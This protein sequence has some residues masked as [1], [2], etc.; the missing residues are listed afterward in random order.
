MFLVSSLR[1]GA[2]REEEEE[3]EEEEEEEEGKE[4][5]EEEEG[6]SRGVKVP[7]CCRLSF[8]S[9]STRSVVSGLARQTPGLIIGPIQLALVLEVLP[10][11]PPTRFS[12]FRCGATKLDTFDLSPPRSA[13]RPME[14]SDFIS[15]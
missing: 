6:D 4:E 11:R 5:D 13:D 2:L 10:P 3:D 15:F 1:H 14:N 9:S 12:V 7:L 8:L